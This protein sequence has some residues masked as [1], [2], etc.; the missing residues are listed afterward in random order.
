MG[1]SD[2]G[3]TRISNIGSMEISNVGNTRISNTLGIRAY[4]ILGVRR[5]PIL[6]NPK[7]PKTQQIN[8]KSRIPITS[9]RQTMLNS[10]VSGDPWNGSLESGSLRFVS[11]E[12]D[13]LQFRA[14]DVRLDW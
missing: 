14:A 4:P 9:L 2:I 10:D 13:S 5:L 3:S 8:N 6:G 12:C 7:T 11:P 1:I